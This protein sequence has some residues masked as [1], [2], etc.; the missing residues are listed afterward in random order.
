MQLFSLIP[1][2]DTTSGLLDLEQREVLENVLAA[3]GVIVGRE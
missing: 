3:T 2:A 1:D